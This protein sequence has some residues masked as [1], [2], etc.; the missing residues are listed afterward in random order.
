MYLAD[1]SHEYQSL[2]LLLQGHCYKLAE[3]KGLAH[4]RLPI[5]EYIQINSRKVLTINHGERVQQ[6]L[7]TRHKLWCTVQ[8]C[9]SLT[10]SP[11]PLCKYPKALL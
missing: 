3:E 11:R 1:F 10:A 8:D 4:A 9:S 7:N 2:P 5:S 6:Q